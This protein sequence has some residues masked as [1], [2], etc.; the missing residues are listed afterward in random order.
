MSIFYTHHVHI[1]T[2]RSHPIVNCVCK[3]NKGVRPLIFCY[4]IGLIPILYFTILLVKK[5]IIV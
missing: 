3:L 1:L 2:L 4:L 5:L